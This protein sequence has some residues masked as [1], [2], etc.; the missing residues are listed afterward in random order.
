MKRRLDDD[1]RDAQKLKLTLMDIVVV[2][3]L[4]LCI[5]VASNFTDS[6]PLNGPLMTTLH[7]I[8]QLCAPLRADSAHIMVA[9]TPLLLP[10]LA[11]ALLVIE[12][13]ERLD[14]VVRLLKFLIKNIEF[15]V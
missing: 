14:F 1:G 3:S 4:L 5:A 7:L 11:I 8:Q 2:A 13:L 6:I 15:E 10:V 9:V 12:L